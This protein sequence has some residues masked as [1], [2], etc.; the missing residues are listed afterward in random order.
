MKYG[1]MRT[2]TKEQNEQRQVYAMHEEGIVDENIYMDKMSGKDFN[3][4]EYQKLVKNLQKG[5]ILYILSIDRLG[6]NYDDI[7]EQWHLITKEIE[8][9]I[10]VIDMPLLN[11]TTKNNDL[12]GRFVADLVLQILSYVAQKE[13]EAIKA[14]QMYGIQK[15]R[16]EGRY[17]K[18]DASDEDFMECKKLVDEGK[19][20]VTTACSRLGITR[21]AWYYRLKIYERDGV[22]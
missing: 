14:R 18:M 9:D 22:L 16:D 10:V 1:Y 15:A 12:T 3:R 6:R 7:I 21:G 19:I 2:S 13:R 5:D 8:A 20:A 11:T 17:R 4:P